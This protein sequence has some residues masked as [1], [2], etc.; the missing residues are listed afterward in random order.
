MAQFHDLPNEIFFYIF[1]QLSP[2]DLKSAVLVSKSWQEVGEDPILWTWAVARV[3]NRLDFEK[4]QIQRLQLLQEV[5]VNCSRPASEY[6]ISTVLYNCCSVMVAPQFHNQKCKM[7]DF[8]I[9]EQLMHSGMQQLFKLLRNIPTLRRISG[10]SCENCYSAVDPDLLVGVLNR[11]KDLH[12]GWSGVDLS[13]KQLELLFTAMAADT[14]VE[15]LYVCG[16]CDL[17]ETSPALLASAVSKV[18]DAAL[19]GFNIGIQHV[20]ALLSAII[21]EDKPLIKLKVSTLSTARIDPDILGRAVNKL[22]E[23]TIYKLN[24][25]SINS[26]KITAIISRLVE[27]ETKLKVLKLLDLHTRDIEEVDQDLIRRAREKIGDFYTIY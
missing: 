24:N 22:E 5:K 23:V 8:G 10:G 13:S 2:Q 20:E 14:R 21:V 9:F 17:S 11:L 12:V 1:K 7:T 19:G 25:D 27:G 16:N 18:K 4:L 15:S 6:Y 3:E 26:D